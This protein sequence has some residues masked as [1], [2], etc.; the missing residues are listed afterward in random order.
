MSQ[1][2][3]DVY[4]G[5]YD[6]LYADKDYAGEC[7]MLERAFAA[8]GRSEVRSILDLGC[9][10]GNHAILLAKSGYRVV[11]VDR[12]Q[13]MLA[14]A[15]HKAAD[16]AP[17]FVA[18]D[19]ASVTL[20]ENFDAV[21]LMFNVLG[22][23]LGEDAEAALGAA[24]RHLKPGGLVVCDFW[25]GPAVEHSPAQ[26][27]HKVIGDGRHRVIRLTRTETDAA[28]Q[29]CDIHFQ[30]W[31]LDGEH[32]TGETDEHHHV[33]YFFAAELERMFQASGLSLLHLGGFPDFTAAPDPQGS[34]T[35]TAIGRRE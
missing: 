34:W 24:S 4:A 1:V 18:G 5:A 29:V 23:M 30:L 35:A 2:F 6:V 26:D 15:R 17:R 22:Y 33:R 32:V 21:V 19:I 10:T 12:S 16:T 11:G 20:D 7:A 27:R 8:Y 9:G 13:A 25:Y 28:R 31:R 3:A 14:V